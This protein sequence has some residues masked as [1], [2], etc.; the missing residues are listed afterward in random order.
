MRPATTPPSLATLIL[1]TALTTLSLNMFLPALAGI[2]EDLGTD[3]ATAGLAVAGYLGV[4][5]GVQLVIGPLSDRIGRRRVVLGALGVF[6]L[7]SLGAALA[8]DITTFL[9]FRVL[10]AGVAAGY[11]VSL[12]IVRDTTGPEGAAARIGY[13]TMVMALA[14]MLGPVLGG[15][16]DAAFGWRACF[17]VYA[18]AGAGLAV[19]VWADLGE[20]RPA[21]QAPRR[22]RAEARALLGEG[23]FWGFAFCTAFSTGA[24]YMFLVGA[25][26]VARVAFGVEPAMIG[27]YLGSITGGFMAGSLIAARVARRVGVTTLVLAGRLVA[28]AGL[29]AGLAAVL[30]GH[31][32]ELAYFGATIF[33]GLGNGISLPGASAGAMSVR[34]ELSG[35]AAGLSSALTLGGGAALT[36]LAG[37]TLE[38]A[39]AAPV[40]IALMLGASAA[41]LAAAVWVRVLE[42]RVPLTG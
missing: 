7:A 39:T 11:S 20:T 15:V 25:P 34:P 35:T 31:L 1:L 38:E 26:L 41:G 40:L 17:W 5:A 29:T 37:H 13:I 30:A 14:P 42:R 32:S 28:C 12:A 6:V 33:V 36:T 3:Y 9:L 21:G 24:F 22:F 16:L 8:G 18:G 10:Q 23:R 2:A 19:L 27:V 4:T